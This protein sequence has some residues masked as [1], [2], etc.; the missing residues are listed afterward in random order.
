ME[1]SEFRTKTDLLAARRLDIRGTQSPFLSSVA[2]R[3]P[4]GP[5]EKDSPLALVVLVGNG[6]ECIILVGGDGC[7]KTEIGKLLS[8]A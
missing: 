7:S 4:P 6:F 8:Y 1:C 2:T 5:E 3:V